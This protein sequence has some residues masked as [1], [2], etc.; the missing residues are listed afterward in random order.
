MIRKMLTFAHLR[1][2]VPLLTLR[3][4]RSPFTGVLRV[5]VFTTFVLVFAEIN[6]LVFPPVLLRAV[7]LVLAILNHS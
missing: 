1:A 3:F 7:C 6:L 2:T 5:A 4:A